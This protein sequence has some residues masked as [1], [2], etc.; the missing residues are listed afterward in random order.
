MPCYKG[1]QRAVLPLNP[2]EMLKGVM[3]RCDEDGDGRL[4]KKELRDVFNTLG[5]YFPGL[6][7]WLALHYADSDGDGYISH[8]EFNKLVN[9][10]IE[11]GYAFK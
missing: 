5:A 9:Y 3:Q 10:C 7:A 4:S 2:E 1:M 8:D 11:C 6:R